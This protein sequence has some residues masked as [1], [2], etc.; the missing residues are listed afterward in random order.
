[1]AG[2]SSLCDYL[3]H[4]VN[5]F[6]LMDDTMIESSRLLLAA[7]TLSAR[8]CLDDHRGDWHH[9]MAILPR[10]TGGTLPGWPNKVS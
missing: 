4:I 1:M 6:T 9:Q 2:S 10:L 7:C 3:F 8:N 5:H